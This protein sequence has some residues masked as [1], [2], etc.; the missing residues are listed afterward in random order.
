MKFGIYGLHE[1]ILRRCGLCCG[2]CYCIDVQVVT[3][4]LT[5]AFFARSELSIFTAK[6]TI[7]YS[8]C[9]CCCCF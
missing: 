1:F 9:C 7:N 6:H 8:I 2:L 4:V 3:D 5:T